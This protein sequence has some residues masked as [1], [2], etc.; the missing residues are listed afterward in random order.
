MKKLILL[1]S[2]L[3]IVALADPRPWMEK[4][5]PNELGVEAFSDSDYPMT[6]AEVEKEIGNVLVRSRI[7]PSGNVF[8][9][10]RLRIVIQCMPSPNSTTFFTISLRIEFL[11]VLTSS[12]EKWQIARLG[13]EPAA[14]YLMR[15]DK[16]YLKST[17]REA[18]EDVIADYLKVN[19]DLAED[20]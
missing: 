1:V 13:E 6:S 9:Y 7:K 14:S 8:E 17:L 10:P 5:N 15:G 18:V 20:E 11:D 3:P 19:F 12:D 2:M 16:D 4:E